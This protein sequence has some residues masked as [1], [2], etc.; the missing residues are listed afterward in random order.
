MSSTSVE[1]VS[2]PIH[3]AELQLTGIEPANLVTGPGNSTTEQ[4]P[5]LKPKSLALRGVNIES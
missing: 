2:S 1:R 3:F 5:Y 4:R